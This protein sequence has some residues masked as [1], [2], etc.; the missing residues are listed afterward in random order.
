MYKKYKGVGMRKPTNRQEKRKWWLD[1]SSKKQNKKKKKKKSFYGSGGCNKNYGDYN[2]P[3]VM[4]FED[5]FEKTYLFL[6]SLRS[7]DIKKNK[8]FYLNLKTLQR[9]TPP[10][11]LS[12]ITEL[13]VLCIRNEIKLKLRDYNSW[14]PVIRVQLR[15]IGLFKLLK[16]FNSPNKMIK[17]H[18]DGNIKYFI[19]IRSEGFD[20]DNRVKLLNDI[21]N[22]ISKNIPNRNELELV[23][24]EAAAN[25]FNHAYHVDDD[26]KFWWLT[27]S[28]NTET[29]MLTIMF[30]DHG[31][32]I[33]LMLKKRFRAYLEKLGLFN[34]SDAEKIKSAT[35]LGTSQ[36]QQEYRGKGFFYIKEYAKKGDKNSVAIYSDRGGY[37]YDGKNEKLVNLE[38]SLKGTLIVWDIE[39]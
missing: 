2:A 38:N 10:A 26:F 14:D 37:I 19:T 7:F 22:F 25:V 13:D 1:R 11:I 33:P 18:D 6:N 35:E 39:V 9:I 36:T 24:S 5:N 23:I 16:I 30:M 8:K 3:T 31:V 32:G 17:P 34:S 4:D 20:S 28:Y 12:L 27:A 21:H 15:D 29:S